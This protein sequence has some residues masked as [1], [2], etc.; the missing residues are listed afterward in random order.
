MSETLGSA[1]PETMQ[2]VLCLGPRDYQLRTVAVPRPGP[3]EVLIKVEA[4]GICASDL[5]CY[6]GAARFWGDETRPAYV[7]TGVIPG[8]EFTG[9]VV[10]LDDQA[11]QRWG[12]AAGDRVVAEQIVPCT[13][14]RYCLDG[15]YWMCDPH[16]IF[17]FKHRTPGAMAEYM[18]FPEHARVHKVSKSLPP[19]HV[20][21]A[22]P[23]ACAL[24]AVER[25]QL[26]FD[27]VVVVAG[28]GPIGLGMIAGAKTRNPKLVIALDM[29][30][31]KLAIAAECG[32]DV[33]INV[34]DGDAVARVKALTDGYGADV[35]FEATGHPSAVRQGLHLLRKLGRFVEYSVFGSDA[36]VDWSIVGDEKELD[37]RGAHSAELLARRD[38]ADRVRRP[39]DGQDLHSSTPAGGIPEWSRPGGQRDGIDQGIDHSLTRAACYDIW[40]NGHQAA[41]GH[42]EP[43]SPMM[44]SW[45]AAQAA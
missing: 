14:C 4:V 39:P 27:D 24:H 42:P 5:K 43:F 25:A 13:Q 15:K 3:G 45:W 35:Y 11:A 12:I 40:G 29:S 1:A 37:I 16:N 17:G 23:L 19:H 10:E 26:T 32:A 38:S 31:D 6:Q 20:A 36:T 21:F 2:A 7:E 33:I 30:A 28:C 9:T 34:A 41:T 22:E 8:H 18:V 44:R